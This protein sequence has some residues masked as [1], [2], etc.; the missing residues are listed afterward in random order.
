MAEKQ[1]SKTAKGCL[2]L[3]ALV[4]FLMLIGVFGSGDRPAAKDAATPAAKDAATQTKKD[5]AK[6]G[7]IVTPNPEYLNVCMDTPE[8]MKEAAKWYKDHAELWR[9][10]ARYGGTTVGP[11]DR[12]KVL[13]P[14][15]GWTMARVRLMPAERKERECYCLIELVKH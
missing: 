12:M 10:I 13:D 9:V 4:T 3:V 7:D 6:R 5:Y 11:N 14:V 15:V 2:V 8:G 1:Q